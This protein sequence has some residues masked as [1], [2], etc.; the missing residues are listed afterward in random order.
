MLGFGSKQ[1][2]E[3]LLH[4][5]QFVHDKKYGHLYDFEKQQWIARENVFVAMDT[6]PSP[7]ETLVMGLGYS[8]SFFGPELGFGWELPQYFPKET[9]ILL[10]KTA[11][12]SKSLSVDFRPPSAGLG[13]YTNFRNNPIPDYRYGA[14]Y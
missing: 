2:M 3:I 13:N 6:S 4:E 14:Y 12:N 7:S 8:S 9:T 10:I 5:E 11:W 1:H